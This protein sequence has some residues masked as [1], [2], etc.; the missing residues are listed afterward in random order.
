MAVSSE[1]LETGLE[2]R[3]P[4]APSNLSTGWVKKGH[5]PT[6]LVVESV[7]DGDASLGHLPEVEGKDIERDSL[8][9][10]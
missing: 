3:V 8:H 4:R 7:E 5:P 6:P 1:T 9:C 10:A 2:A